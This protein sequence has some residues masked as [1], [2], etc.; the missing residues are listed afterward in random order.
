MKKT[1]FTVIAALLC[2][3]QAVSA[4]NYTD[5]V[6][7]ESVKPFFISV[8]GGPSITLSENVR[9]YSE[10]DS[11]KEL[12]NFAQGGIAFGKN[13]SNRY[14]GRLAFE[15]GKNDSACNTQNTSAY[16]FYPYSFSNASA[17]ADWIINGGNVTVPKNFNWRVYFGAGAAYSFDFS[18]SGHPWQEVTADNLCFAFRYGLIL[19]YIFNDIVGI[20]VDGNHEWFTDN[21]NGMFPRENGNGIHETDYGKHL[22]FPFDM[23]LNVNLGLAIHF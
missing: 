4:Q 15:F 22:G 13:F 3:V 9:Q 14:G 5:T 8:Y 18:D 20:Y 19:E 17:F 10:F 2:T 6:E 23:K 21:F 16:G 7:E 12:I 11:S 1:I